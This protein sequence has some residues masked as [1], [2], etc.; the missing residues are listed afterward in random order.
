VLQAI[1]SHPKFAHE[2][3]PS[4]EL[5]LLGLDIGSPKALQ[6]IMPLEGKFDAAG[7]ME[8]GRTQH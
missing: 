6:T 1:D 2:P 3:D 5:S 4:P 7:K 8:V